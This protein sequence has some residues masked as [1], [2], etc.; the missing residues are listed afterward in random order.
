MSDKDSATTGNTQLGVTTI[1]LIVGVSIGALLLVAAVGAA[2]TGCVVCSK[3]EKA[4]NDGAPRAVTFV[5]R[6][7]EM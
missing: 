6:M 5:V 4:T 7:H 1:T 3:L 2:V